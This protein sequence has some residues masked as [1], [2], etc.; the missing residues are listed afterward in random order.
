ML[1]D[2]TLRSV[3]LHRVARIV[4]FDIAGALDGVPH[5]RLARARVC[6]DVDVHSRFL[7]NNWL[8]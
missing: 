3:L 6:F 7:I 2:L 5:C 4:P 1:T 8:R